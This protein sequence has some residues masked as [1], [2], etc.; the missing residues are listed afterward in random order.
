MASSFGQALAYIGLGLF[1]VIALFQLIT[2]PVEYDASRRAKAQLL[3]LGLV[4]H[5]EETGVRKVLNAAA[6]T[7]VAAMVTA[8][9]QLLYWLSVL[10]RR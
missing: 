4:T 2:L 3:D 1:A 5:Q 10:N 8:V 6:M 9:M 7:Y